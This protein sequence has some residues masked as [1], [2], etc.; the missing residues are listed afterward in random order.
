MKRAPTMST[1]RL[2]SYSAAYFAAHAFELMRRDFQDSVRVAE[3]EA[4]RDAGGYEQFCAREH[5]SAKAL[6]Q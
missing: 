6:K 4:W 5:E 3:F 2:P 1:Y